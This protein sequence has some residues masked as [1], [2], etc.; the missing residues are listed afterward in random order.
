MLRRSLIGLWGETLEEAFKAAKEHF[1]QEGYDGPLVAAHDSTAVKPVAEVRA[2][3][4]E[5]GRKMIQIDCFSSG[6][7]RLANSLEGA[8]QLTTL[9]GSTEHKAVLGTLM[10][11]VPACADTNVV[12]FSLFSCGRW[13]AQYTGD[14]GV[15]GQDH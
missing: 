12:P 3:I 8:Q 15:G 5:G 9:M 6:P 1:E 7:V 10:M 2:V 4:V 14:G 13:R 11:L